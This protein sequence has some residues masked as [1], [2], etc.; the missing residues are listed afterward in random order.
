MVA[1]L[2]APQSLVLEPTDLVD[3][4]VFSSEGEQ[5][6]NIQP[7]ASCPDAYRSWRQSAGNRIDGSFIP[8]KH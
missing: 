4:F 3:S 1:I 6:S 8:I 2:I 7:L 5:N